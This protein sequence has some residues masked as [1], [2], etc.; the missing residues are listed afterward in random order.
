[1]PDRILLL[2]RDKDLLYTREQIFQRAGYV[3]VSATNLQ[4]ALALAV[5]Q[6]PAVILVGHT[7]SAEEQRLFVERLHETHPHLRILLLRE[8]L[9]DPTILLAA[10][11][12]FLRSDPATARV[13]VLY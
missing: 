4:S 10:C 8:G 3:T 1:M 11:E 7:F 5:E 13:Q 6:E 2:S 12:S 9:I